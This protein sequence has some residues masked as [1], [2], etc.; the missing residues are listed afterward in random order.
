MNLIE[1]VKKILTT[2][3]TE[4]L[5][6]ETETTNPQALLTSYVAPLAILSSL[7]GVLT[8]LLW[9]GTYG[10]KFWLVSAVI[11]LVSAI[12]GYYI[13]TYVIDA[14]A[15][16]FG[17]EKNIN[18]S[19]QLVAYSNTAAW[20][21]GFLSFIPVIGWLAAIAGAIYSIYLLYLGIGP[22]K[23][24]P[25]DKKVGYM[26]V[27]FLVIIVIGVVVAAILRAVIYPAMGYSTY[28]LWGY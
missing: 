22:M 1:R 25:E 14:L 23:K 6:I 13:S 24:T 3:K 2:P 21:G 4:W 27:S 28:G 11:G 12:V 16:S 10:M 9:A 26:I 18:K 17:S 19:A 8:G 20:V 7:S 15:S 5:V